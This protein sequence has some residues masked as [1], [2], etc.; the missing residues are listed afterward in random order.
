MNHRHFAGA[1][2]LLI[3]LGG[4]DFQKQA[5]ATFGDQ[6]FKT[7][8]PPPSGKLSPVLLTTR[9]LEEMTSA[10]LQRGCQS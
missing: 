2:I 10:A 6:H 8:I 7:T 5:D 9:G 4:C 1:L 3:A